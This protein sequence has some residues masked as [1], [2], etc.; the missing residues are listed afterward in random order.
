MINTDLTLKE[1]MKS[2]Q[3][4]RDYKLDKDSYI[5]CHIDGRAFS[6]MIKKRFRL[7]F[8]DEFMRMMDDTA[9]YVCENVQGAKLAYVQSD[10]ISIVITN[11]KYE[12]GELLQGS[13]FFD[14]RLCKLQSIIASLATAKFNQLYTIRM[15]SMDSDK[16]FNQQINEMPLIQFDCKCWDVKMYEDMFAWFKFRQNDCI[17]NSK[18][19]FAQAYCSHKD[20]L[21]KNSDEQILYCKLKTGN[22]WDALSGQYK[23]GRL[24]YRR[25]YPMQTI[26]PKTGERVNIIRSQYSSW[27]VDSPFTFE[28]FKG[29]DLVPFK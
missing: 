18:Q 14:Y 11:F 25:T 1:R 16:S 29:W 21:N 20:L 13:S 28:E 5:L 23:Y 6:K 17:R 10:E 2:L 8:D 26:N 12:V 9:A 15:L 7:P 27:I 19:Q 24:V 4:T 3:A 22:D